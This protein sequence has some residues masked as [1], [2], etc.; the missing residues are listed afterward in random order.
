[1]DREPHPIPQ[2]PTAQDLLHQVESNGYEVTLEL[3]GTAQK[4]VTGKNLF[5]GACERGG[6]TLRDAYGPVSLE[7]DLQ[8]GRCLR[9]QSED[10]EQAT[11]H[12][13]ALRNAIMAGK[14]RR[15][16]AMYRGLQLVARLVDSAA[17]KVCSER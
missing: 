2:P 12:G 3:R 10:G 16:S 7:L 15:N 8:A 17:R 4:W 6:L 13:Q 11:T 14:V 5:I 1:M 9:W